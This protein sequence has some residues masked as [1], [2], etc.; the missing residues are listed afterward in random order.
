MFLP[1]RTAIAFL[2]ILPI[3]LPAE[4]GQTELKESSLYF[5][6]AGWLIGAILAGCGW[7]LLSA[8]LSAWPCAVILLALWAVLTRGLHLD[9]LADLFD[10]L[11]GGH[12][13]ARRLEIMKDSATGAFG[14]IALI[15]HLLAKLVFLAGLIESLGGGVL[16]PLAAVPALGRWVMLTL[17]T[18]TSYP[19][20][21]GT[22]HAFVGQMRLSALLLTSLWLAPFLFWFWPGGVALLLGAL[23]P[24]LW[25]RFKAQKAFGGV[26]GDVLGACCELAETAALFAGLLFCSLP[27]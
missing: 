1:L 20:S 9:G 23:L 19:R 3:P 4:V 13:P 11:G 18:G 21:Q 25:L 22:G 6:A 8:G 10:G 27:A 2:T 26:T 5:P 24:G 16:F 14:A 7:L 15:C 12:D 17:F